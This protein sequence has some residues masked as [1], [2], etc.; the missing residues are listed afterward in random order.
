MANSR[1]GLLTDRNKSIKTCLFLTD[2]P[3]ASNAVYRRHVRAF[4]DPLAT[5]GDFTHRDRLYLS[6]VPS[7]GAHNHVRPDEESRS[8]GPAD[9][10]WPSLRVC[11]GTGRR[12]AQRQFAP[13]G[14]V[15]LKMLTFAPTGAIVAAPTCSLPEEIGGARN[16][17]YRYTWVRDA[18]FTLYAFLRLSASTMPRAR[19]SFRISRGSFRALMRQL[20]TESPSAAVSVAGKRLFRQQRQMRAKPPT[21]SDN[22]QRQNACTNRRQFGAIRNEPGNLR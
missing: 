18:A 4:C 14:S 1:L 8:G 2:K 11:S 15:G 10:K 9:F 22:L 3:V 19:A 20:R 5:P 21:G 7:N 12:R 13:R 16:W 17:D 6:T